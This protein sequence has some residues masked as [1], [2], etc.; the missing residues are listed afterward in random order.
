MCIKQTTDTGYIILANVSGFSGNTNVYLFKIDKYGAFMWDK[1]YADTAVFWAEK[2]EVTSDK[3][4]IITGY[5]NKEA[6][7]GYN[8][9]LI[10]T[11]SLG[12]KEWKKYYGGP[13]WD[14]GTDVTID[15]SG[16]YYVTGNTY[17]YGSGEKDVYL[18]KMNSSGDTLWTKTFG[19]LNEEA[20]NSL[21][22]CQNNDIV[23]T[24]YTNSF[25]AGNYDYL[26]LRYDSSGQLLWNRTFGGLEDDK[27]LAVKE[28]PYD[29]HFIIGGYSNSYG[30][31]YYYFYFIKASPDGLLNWHEISGWSGGDY[32]DDKIFSLDLTY[33]SGFVFIGTSTW[34]IY[35][36][37]FLL[38]TH[39]NGQW[40]FSTSHGGLGTDDANYIIQTFDSCFIIVGT[41]EWFGPN[42]KD[43]YVIKTGLDGTT[44]PYNNIEDILTEENTPVKIYP[45]P[46]NETAKIEVPF[47]HTEPLLFIIYDV[48]GIKVKE[49]IITNNSFLNRRDFKAG[50]YY[51]QLQKN[52]ETIDSGSFVV[53]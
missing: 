30:N 28:I 15:S 50:I 23:I 6:A 17:S 35:Q 47:N 4:F 7:M 37:L 22:V 31:G 38:K 21:V 11:D 36:D 34:N 13:D 9:F 33:D 27:A 3:G 42:L 14:F 12:N 48:L 19:G 2:M 8:I 10:K 51:Y 40:H 29:N 45:N 1:I 24:G 53:Y 18:L 26:L 41:S 25:G 39:E 49:E 5:T 32:G 46:F 16:N 52:A 44:T 20:G 43:I